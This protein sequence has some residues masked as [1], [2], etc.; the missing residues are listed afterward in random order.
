M[1]WKKITLKIKRK[2]KHGSYKKKNTIKS[3]PEYIE[4]RSQ[5]DNTQNSEVLHRKAHTENTFARKA[6]IK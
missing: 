2:G 6:Q 4:N 5:S 3:K 1:T